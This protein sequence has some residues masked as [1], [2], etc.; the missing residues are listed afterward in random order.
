MAQAFHRPAP[1]YRDTIMPDYDLIERRSRDVIQAWNASI[2][3]DTRISSSRHDVQA[4]VQDDMLRQM[5]REGTLGRMTLVNLK[6]ACD[7]YGLPK[8]GRKA[9]VISTLST[10]LSTH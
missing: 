6:Q 9:D 7:L 3:A 2:Q 8:Y 10:Y 5:H 1:I 4:G